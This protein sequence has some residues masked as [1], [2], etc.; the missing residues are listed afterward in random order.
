MADILHDLII[1][2]SQSNV[3]Q[4][5]SSP[6]LINQWWTL[7]C[8]G[9]ARIG[10]EYRLFF[11]EGFDWRA[12]VISYELDNRLDLKMT[13]CDHDWMDTVV[14]FHLEAVKVGTKLRFQHRYWKDWNDHFRTSSYCWAM[15]LRI[16]KRYLE[17][18]EEVHYSQRLNA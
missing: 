3:F 7:A 14:G 16:L 12:K 2:S 13:I 8:E 6:D 10:A 1:E 4:G 11:G 17:F 9:G 5:V 18:G 15:Y